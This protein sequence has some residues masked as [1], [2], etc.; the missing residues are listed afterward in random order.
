[1]DSNSQADIEH[2]RVRY[3]KPILEADAPGGHSFFDGYTVIGYD[4]PEYYNKKTPCS[5][6]KHLLRCQSELAAGKDDEQL[7]CEGM[8]LVQTGGEVMRL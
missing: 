8:F 7:V 6:C 4:P 1:M 5:A 3:A 2:N